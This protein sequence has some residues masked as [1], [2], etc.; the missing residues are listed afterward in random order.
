MPPGARRTSTG[1]CTHGCRVDEFK[2]SVPLKKNGKMKC[3]AISRK[4]PTPILDLK[5]DQVAIL[6]VFLFV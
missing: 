4:K 3:M 5:I 1:R 6:V 2:T